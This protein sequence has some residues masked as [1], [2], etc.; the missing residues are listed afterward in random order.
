MRVALQKAR[1]AHS[2]ALEKL[3]E[4]TCTVYERRAVQ[5]ED[6][7]LTDWQEVAVLEDQ[8][9]KLSFEK[10]SQV[11]QTDSAAELAQRIK[12]FISPNIEI[13][14]GSKI[15]IVHLG[16]ITDYTYSGVPAV[17]ETHQEILLDLFERWA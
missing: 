2:R 6:S 16:M 14:P 10:V 13:K 7:H 17:Y 5:D 15:S 12:L 3:Y 11:E 4:D 8:P 1:E 9:C